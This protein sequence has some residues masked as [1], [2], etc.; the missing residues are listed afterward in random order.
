MSLTQREK[1][2]L[3]AMADGLPTKGIARQLG[4]ALKTVESHKDPGRSTSWERG[5]RRTPFPSRTQAR[6]S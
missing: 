1:Q 5:R 3:T 2:V 4:V 6:T